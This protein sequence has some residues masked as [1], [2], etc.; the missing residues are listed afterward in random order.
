[1]HVITCILYAYYY[2][3]CYNKF[4]NKRPCSAWG[5]DKGRGG[6]GYIFQ[7]ISNCDMQRIKETLS[8]I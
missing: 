3:I 8:V 7:C 1:M 4:S 5:E 6:E 2:I